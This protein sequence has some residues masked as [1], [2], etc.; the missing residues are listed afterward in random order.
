MMIYT[1]EENDISDN[2]VLHRIWEN[3]EVNKVPKLN[4]DNIV[5]KYYK[6]LVKDHQ[7]ITR[8]IIRYFIDQ[9]QTQ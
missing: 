4:E 1:G 3:I 7:E 8:N 5:D 2:S 9:Y 6:D